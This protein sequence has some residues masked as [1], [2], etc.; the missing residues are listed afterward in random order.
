LP[1]RYRRFRQNNRQNWAQAALLVRYRTNMPNI[2][3]AAGASLDYLSA[4][5][6]RK[7]RSDAGCEAGER[8]GEPGMTRGLN[9][10]PNAHG[11]EIKHPQA[12]CEVCAVR[13]PHQ[14]ERRSIAGRLVIRRVCLSCNNEEP[15]QA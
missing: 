5:H 11:N 10:A 13:T 4:V 7:T 12:Y 2:R 8:V 14:H 9:A 1:R 15:K 6:C 3:T